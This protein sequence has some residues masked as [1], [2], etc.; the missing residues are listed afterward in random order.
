VA[1]YTAAT[2]PE[3]GRL[4]DLHLFSEAERPVLPQATGSIRPLGAFPHLAP[5]FDRVV[6]VVGNSHFH[7]R[8]F[9][10]LQRY[11]AACI[12]HDGRMVD[13]YSGLLGRERAL[14]AAGR[15][16]GRPVDEPE[17]DAWLADQSRLKALF[18][19]EVVEAASPMIVH[20]RVTACEIRERHGVRAMY[21]PFTIYRPLALAD[22]TP[23][24]RTRA[25]TRL[26][27][28]ENEVAIATFGFV[29][30][31]KAPEECIWALDLLRGWGVAAT[32]HFVGG[33]EHMV[34]EAPRCTPSS[35]ASDYPTRSIFPRASCR[36]RPTATIWLAP[37]W[38]SS[39]E[40]MV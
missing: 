18:L 12:A 1:D 11:G 22:L 17:L 26:G 4:V 8:I 2:C 16:L 37:I 3:L 25:R 20:S 6:S 7:L 31:T 30:P 13:F 36:N 14:A 19:G 27:I 5:G 35:N 10:L 29:H 9:E 21:V 28:A 15:E 40:R 39:C 23:E 32:L 24:A 38:G 33:T 34:T